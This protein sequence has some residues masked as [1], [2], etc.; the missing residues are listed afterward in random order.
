MIKNG[1]LDDMNSEITQEIII[2]MMRSKEMFDVDTSRKDFFQLL[3]YMNIDLTGKT[4]SDLTKANSIVANYKD[5][6]SNKKPA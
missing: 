1:Y 5:Y 6:M 2:N 3:F 4:K